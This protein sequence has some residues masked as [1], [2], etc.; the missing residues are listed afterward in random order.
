M[1]TAE[2]I[3]KKLEELGVNDFFGVSGQNKLNFVNC[4]KNKTNI[5]F[6][7]CLNE[8]DAGNAASGYAKI[9]G[10]ASAIFKYGIS[11]LNFLSTISACYSENIPVVYI[12]ELPS[13]NEN[14]KISEPNYNHSDLI[15]F[16]KNITSG[17]TILS[18]SNSKSEIDKLFKTLVRERKPV[19]IGIPEEI[20]NAE[21]SDEYSDNEWESDKKNLLHAVSKIINKINNSK[22]PVIIGDGLIKAFDAKLEY[23]EFVSKS[24]I[25]VTNFLMGTNIID[26]EYEKYLGGYFSKFKNPIVQKYVEDS[27]CLIS[28]GALY[29]SI[30]SFGESLPFN[31][32]SHIAIYGTYTYVDNQ[33]F[34][35]IKM[36][37][38]LSEITKQ[39]EPSS[40]NIEKSNIGYR[41]KF[42]EDEKLSIDAIFTKLQGFIRENDIL[43][44][45][46]GIIPFGAFQMK[47]PAGVEIISNISSNIKGWATSAG[48]GVC[49]AKSG[50]RVIVI[51]GDGS[52]QASALEIG[53]YF[54]INSKPIIV[55]INNKGFSLNRYLYGDLE[56][57]SCNIPNMNYAKFVRSFD[58]DVWS[59]KA[60]TTDDFEKALKVTQIM[61]KMCY[62]EAETEPFDIPEI[63]KLYTG[64]SELLPSNN[65]DNCED[66]VIIENNSDE[67]IAEPEESI[68]TEETGLSE[69]ESES[70]NTDIS[71]KSSY[72]DVDL[73][74]YTSSG[75]K[76]ETM[77]H[78]NLSEEDTEADDNE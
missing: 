62:I 23:Q 48:I 15:K 69:P 10:F 7:Q 26:M 22:N 34:D 16:Y 63:A 73:S 44:I 28:V 13:S 55:V 38:V 18:K 27:D 17:C 43:V 33:K 76:Y 24:Q 8:F 14:D 49:A 60:G 78:A 12:S 31:I 39:I 66:S 46:N 56:S 42:S 51:T 21:I 74:K 57:E 35:N 41:D 68:I 6:I 20:A 59:I 53:T 64:Y 29:G 3:I 71:E 50:A 52:H 47:L 19:Y 30:N 32:N 2:Y 75:F 5:N 58:G 40:I 45:D 70:E 11:E 37:D 36:A 54:K 77:V 4:I 67:N 72:D 9:R 65:E 61:N 1:N 25:P